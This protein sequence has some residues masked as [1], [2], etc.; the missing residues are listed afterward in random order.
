VIQPEDFGAFFAEVNDGH[1]PFD[2][3][4]RLLDRLVETGSWPNLISAPTG[5]GK[6]SVVEVHVF[7]CAL[8]ASGHI[9]RVPR[10]L[11]LVVNRRALVDSQAQRSELIQQA[12]RAAPTESLLG[13]VSAALRSLRTQR[14]PLGESDAFD[15]VDMRG[16]IPPRREWV[17]DPAACQIITATP[18]MWGSRVLFRGYGTSPGARPRQAGLLM[19]DSVLVL[20]EAHLNRQLL[21]T[22]RRAAQ[23]AAAEADAIGVPVLQVV[24]T[25]ATPAGRTSTGGE[26]LSVVAV[27]QSD[28]N[29]EGTLTRRLTTPK[30]VRYIGDPSWPPAKSGSDRDRYI[31]LMVDEVLQHHQRFGRTVGCLVNTVAMAVD[32][33]KRLT[34]EGLCTEMVVG[35]MRPYD[36]IVLQQRRPGLLT[37]KGNP[38]VDV[39]VGTQTLEV[40]VDLDFSS[41][42]T[43][44][45]SAPAMAQ[46]VG[47]VNRVGKF[48]ST[49]VCVIGPDPDSALLVG[50]DADLSKFNVAPYLQAGDAEA[51]AHLREAW[52][53]LSRRRDDPMG[54]S[55]WALSADPPPDEHLR[56][57]LLQRLEPHD[58]WFLARTG[59]DLFDEPDLEL[60]LRDDLDPDDLMCGVV[61]RD[62][63]PDDTPAALGL[64]RAT[65]PTNG[66]VYPASMFNT[67]K[68]LE[69][70][71]DPATDRCP[72]RAFRVRAGEIDLVETPRD[73]RTGD[74]VIVDR[75]H[76]VCN[77]GVVTGTP[78]EEGSDV[79]EES[80]WEDGAEHILRFVGARTSW[81]AELL[82]QFADLVS[83]AGGDPDD[84]DILDLV[85]TFLDSDPRIQHL[86]GSNTDSRD[87]VAAL[88]IS[89]GGLEE[90][91][92]RWL[93]VA[94]R[95]V[96][97]VGDRTRQVWT[98]AQN[99]VLLD[100]HNADVADRAR[101]LADRLDLSAELHEA[102]FHSGLFHDTGKSDVRFQRFSLGNAD[103]DR[104]NLAKSHQPSI[105]RVRRGAAGGLP[106]G[107]RHEQLSAAVAAVALD[108]EPNLDL[109]LRLV[110]TSHGRGRPGFPHTTMDLL[111]P[112]IAKD[113]PRTHRA[114]S[115]FDEG[116][117]DSI[118]ES[119]HRSWGVWGCAYLESVLRAADTQISMEGR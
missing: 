16:G 63:L 42:V 9:Q 75:G 47:R 11:A 21:T 26:E 99:P 114:R 95:P 43:E 30:P 23:L 72:P 67:R 5:S 73:V 96:E 110:G 77:S 36:R 33:T 68:L 28:L 89:Y 14:D 83:E 117:W 113:D 31:T 61:V 2:W 78:T 65:M 64:L 104:H 22:A 46:R 15:I 109:I 41:A 52:N 105:R 10:R 39:L 40:G 3:Q 106:T 108:Q 1:S 54:I 57:V 50:N 8:Y 20:D 25:T 53:W 45:A 44:F 111:N 55:P 80:V 58:L 116:G 13:R 59:N 86:G 88:E 87:A 37:I 74:I 92:T 70:V 79:Y 24:A 27:E 115:L 91:A 32:I 18:D 90:D 29:G 69:S 81:E 82:E 34:A 118:I 100:D 84:R 51:V 71:L 17:N 98:S 48:S 49:E 119:T 7:A 85:I 66:E 19:F 4:S 6:S 38:D 102:F 93:V 35:R 97:S 62:H 103:T 76:Q 107:W 12:L 56:R 60:W 112:D 94:I 101:E